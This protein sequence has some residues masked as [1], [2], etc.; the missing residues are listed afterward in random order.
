MPGKITAHSGRA[1]LGK[2]KRPNAAT[3][4]GAQPGAATNAEAT[5][6]LP[7]SAKAAEAID[8]TGGR[9]RGAGPAQQKGKNG[10]LQN[11]KNVFRGC[12]VDESGNKARAHIGRRAGTLPG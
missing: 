8:K 3:L 11:C 6:Q 7:G 4:T 2:F 5:A 1:V 9:N 10:N 12:A